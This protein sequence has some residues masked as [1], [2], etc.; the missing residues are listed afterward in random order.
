MLNGSTRHRRRDQSAER[1]V[2]LPPDPAVLEAL[3]G[4]HSLESAI[5]DI[6]DNSI[7][8]NA[9]R[10]RVRFLAEDSRLLGIQIR[11]DGKGMPAEH[12]ESALTLGSRREYQDS[13]LGHFGIGLKAASMR[14]T[15]TLT[16][17]SAHTRDGVLEYSGIELS[18]ATGRR[19]IGALILS[20][21]R[22]EEGYRYGAYSDA[23]TSGTVVQWSEIKGASVSASR[24][25]RQEWLESTV[26]CIR[27]ALGLIFHR[28]LEN[29]DIQLQLDVFDVVQGVPGP[30]RTVRPVN[31]FAYHL[32]GNRNFPQTLSSTIAE[33]LRV[34]LRCHVLPPKG[35]D[36]LGGAKEDWQGLY[37]YRND[38]LLT[39]SA[40][41]QGLATS[42]REL[43]LARVSLDLTESLMPFVKPTP[44]KTNVV[45]DADVQR[46]LESATSDTSGMTF[47]EYLDAAITTMKESNRRSTEKPVTEIDTGLPDALIEVIGE[48]F[49]WR[50]G[51]DP[52]SIVW[53]ELPSNR[54]FHV[55]L[56]QR[57][58]QVNSR[59]REI[60]GDES[61]PSARMLLA[62]LFIL[63]EENFTR[64]SHI[65]SSTVEHLS[66]IESVLLA[67]IKYSADP[68]LKPAVT[69]RAT[70]ASLRSMLHATAQKQQAA[71]LQQAQVIPLH[72][73]D[74]NALF[75]TLDLD[76]AEDQL[77]LITVL[78]DEVSPGKSN[79]EPLCE[80]TPETLPEPASAVASVTDD[81]RAA[82][83]PSMPNSPISAADLEAFT[84][85]CS[86][87][88]IAEIAHVLRLS[89]P[90]IVLSL[91]RAFFG[92]S[93]TE[94]DS[95]L[96]P[97]H[98]MPYTPS[99]RERILHLFHNGSGLSIVEIAQQ[100][101]RTPFAIAWRLLDSPKRPIPINKRV[102]RSVRRRVTL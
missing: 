1:W 31:P 85:Y 12:L 54:F 68:E 3:G 26:E 92:E 93:A 101:G 43:K 62:L 67:A 23:E 33:G 91:G 13:D 73:Q 21:S 17:Y 9:G 27:S 78:R 22:A 57:E 6:I 84:R 50:A 40:G 89:E 32:S 7:D 15:T 102:R 58:L 100:V 56:S 99:E 30:P 77:D 70:P 63:T 44:E 64:E 79:D 34:D 55:E 83:L 47:T 18:S 19:E 81:W 48:N 37:V 52:I 24:G 82:T 42:K 65:R 72:T 53:T 35:N 20:V 87:L 98:G 69:L 86:G 97:Y 25:D 28:L 60:F 29:G 41:W 45:F 39:A 61:A 94:D 10:V 51:K 75:S 16:V 14:H 11:D 76:V 80:S 90:E 49:G 4:G 59:Y 74:D 8:A 95:T 2:Q 96:A 71:R 38:R 36:Q 46:M 88:T 5:A 66:K